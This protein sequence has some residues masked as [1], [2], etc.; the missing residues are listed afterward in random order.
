MRISRVVCAIFR[1]AAVLLAFSLLL[2][3]PVQQ[4]GGGPCIARGPAVANV[5]AV[6]WNQQPREAVPVSQVSPR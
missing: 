4:V 1:F 3:L 2:A 6:F 5:S